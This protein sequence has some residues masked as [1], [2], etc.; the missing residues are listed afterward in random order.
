MSA[1]F[2]V[3]QALQISVGVAQDDDGIVALH[4]LP[5]T[6]G[7]DRVCRARPARRG[8]SARPPFNMDLKKVK[9]STMTFLDSKTMFLKIVENTERNCGSAGGAG[10]ENHVKG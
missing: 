2:P 3:T 7:D 8:S 6:D 5:F 4:L 9:L 10:T 1:G